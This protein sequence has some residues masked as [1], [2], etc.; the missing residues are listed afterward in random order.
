[1]DLVYNEGGVNMALFSIIIL[2]F[3]AVGLGIF[4]LAVYCLLLGIKALKIYIN[5]NNY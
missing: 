2:I 3:Y 1:M 5:K 4:G